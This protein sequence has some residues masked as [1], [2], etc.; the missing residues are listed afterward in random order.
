MAQ[1]VYSRLLIV[2][3]HI[4]SVQILGILCFGVQ[5]QRIIPQMAN[6]E[7]VFQTVRFHLK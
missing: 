2:G 5:Q 1:H 4:P 3:K 7:T 6:G